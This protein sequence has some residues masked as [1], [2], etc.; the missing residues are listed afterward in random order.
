MGTGVLFIDSSCRWIGSF[1][2][3]FLP[4]CIKSSIS[5][6]TTGSIRSRALCFAVALMDLPVSPQFWTVYIAGVAY[7]LVVLWTFVLFSGCGGGGFHWLGTLQRRIL[8][9]INCI[10]TKGEL[11]VVLVYVSE[12]GCR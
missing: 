4:F 8:W 9:C 5:A 11:A 12:G 10:L 2:S 7:S 6:V 1:N 3:F